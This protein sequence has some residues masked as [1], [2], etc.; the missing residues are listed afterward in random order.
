MS[1]LLVRALLWTLALAGARWLWRKLRADA[2]RVDAARPHAT[3]LS[4]ERVD[5]L[6]RAAGVRPGTMP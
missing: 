3:P 6:L 4:A 2:P 1:R 5:A